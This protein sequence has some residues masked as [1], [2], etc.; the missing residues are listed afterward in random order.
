MTQILLLKLQQLI[1][2]DPT[3]CL[4]EECPIY[5]IEEDRCNYDVVLSTCMAI[6]M[7]KFKERNKEEE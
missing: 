4:K 1:N 6:L 2:C 5:Q 3:K 7:D